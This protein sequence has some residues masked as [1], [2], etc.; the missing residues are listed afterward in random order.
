MLRTFVFGLLALFLVTA[1]LW[2][3]DGV[4][5]GFEKHDLIV[6]IGDKQHTLKMEHIKVTDVEGKELKGKHIG[7][8]LKKDTKIE[9]VE[10][11][12]KIVEIKVKK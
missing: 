11:D 7:D 12:G 2:A 9:L 10:K 3:A 6:K 1:T 8:G 4:V 5:V